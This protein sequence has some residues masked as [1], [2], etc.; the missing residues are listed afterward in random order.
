MTKPKYVFFASNEGGHFSQL[1][2]L[3]SLF[4]KY[5][6]VIVT[7]NERASKNMP[8]LH[9]VVAIEF[10]DADVQM[11]KKL[12][13]KKKIVTRWDYLLGYCKLFKQCFR[14]CEKY[15]PKVIVSTGSDIAVPLALWGKFNG[16][17]VIY[18][19]TR[20]KVYSKTLTGKILTHVA[21][22]II[23]Q[24]PEMIRVYKNKAEYYGV[25]I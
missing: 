4:S 6:S 16:S 12:V 13:G 1:M 11:R 22:K 25:L 15:R 3:H 14:I 9:D 17:K 23:V 21:D 19:E 2:A 24:W 8:E 5:S 7:D 20:A 18:I 10:A